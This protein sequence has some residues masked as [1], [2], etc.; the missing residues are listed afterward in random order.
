MKLVVGNLHEKL[1]LQKQLRREQWE[2]LLH[3]CPHLPIT[4]DDF[5]G[6]VVGPDLS[7]LGC[8]LHCTGVVFP[9]PLL[10]ARANLFINHPQTEDN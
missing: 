8:Q 9:D 10:S 4:G 3:P 5:A 6:L 2:L 7:P 1:L